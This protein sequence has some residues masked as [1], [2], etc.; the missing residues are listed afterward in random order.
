[1]GRLPTLFFTGLV[2]V[3]FILS[4]LYDVF[5]NYFA[6]VLGALNDFNMIRI[7]IGP[8]LTHTIG[9]LFTTV[10]L[11]ALWY[12]FG[13]YQRNQEIKKNTIL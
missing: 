12:V 13:I 1:V 10:G 9:L 4:P 7:T 6:F 8:L 11:L 3:L 5:N 2:I